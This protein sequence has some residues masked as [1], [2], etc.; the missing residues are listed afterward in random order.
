[1]YET[2]LLG[3]QEQGQPPPPRQHGGGGVAATATAT[4]TSHGSRHNNPLRAECVRWLAR[5][6][7]RAWPARSFATLAKRL[8]VI[9]SLAGRPASTDKKRSLRSLTQNNAPLNW[10]KRPAPT[11]CAQAEVLQALVRARTA[12][13]AVTQWLEASLALAALRQQGLA[14]SGHWLEPVREMLQ[15]VRSLARLP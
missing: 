12:S 9:I 5:H 4:A 13:T 7:R 8:Q 10:Q 15:A 6:F 11:V 3:G 2:A 1:M 14:G